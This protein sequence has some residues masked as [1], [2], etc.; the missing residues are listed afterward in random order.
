M[1]TPTY[2][3]REEAG[4]QINQHALMLAKWKPGMSY[5]TAWKEVVPCFNAEQRKEAQT[6][7]DSVLRHRA[8]Q[9]MLKFAYR[10]EGN[11]LDPC[12]SPESKGAAPKFIR[13]RT[14]SQNRE[15]AEL[16]K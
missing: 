7:N 6:Y 13:A 10:G 5:E 12:F 4:F 15:T 8:R 3:F 9:R 2:S 11:R 1:N 16:P 14:I